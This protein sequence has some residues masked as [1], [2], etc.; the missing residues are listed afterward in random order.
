MF[1]F[2]RTATAKN[3]ATLVPALQFAAEVSS[4]LNRRYSLNVKFGTELFGAP[5]IHWQFETDSLDKLQ[6]LNVK[7]LQDR[8]YLGMIEKYKDSWVDGSLQ[9]TVLAFPD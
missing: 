7:L 5:R 1:R 9:D 4:Y 6:Q 2:M 3:A 8:E